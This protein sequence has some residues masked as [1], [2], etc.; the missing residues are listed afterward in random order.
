MQR[1]QVWLLG[2]A[3]FRNPV[4]GGT[5]GWETLGNPRLSL[6]SHNNILFIMRFSHTQSTNVLIPLLLLLEFG[7][8]TKIWLFYPEPLT[9]QSSNVWNQSQKNNYDWLRFTAL[10]QGSNSM[11]FGNHSAKHYWR[12]TLLGRRVII[13]YQ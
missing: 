5:Q 7:S 1:L 11:L 12:I 4:P 8:T 10:L 3:M 9:V 2:Q 13:C 6:T